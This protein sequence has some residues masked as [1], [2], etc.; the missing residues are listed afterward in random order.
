V[1]V[2]DHRQASPLRPLPPAFADSVASLHRVAESIVAPARKPDNEIA[3]T[4]TPGGFGTPEFEFAGALRQVRVEGAELVHRVGAD[5]RRAPLTTLAEAA[6]AVA[7]LLPPDTDL[8][9][10]AL[11]IDAA[12]VKAL[13]DCYA[14]GA[15]VLSELGA[16]TSPEDEATPPRLWPEHFD[17]AVELGDEAGGRRANYGL[18]PGDEDHAE[19][20]LYVGPWSAEVSG[21]L[22]QASGFKGAELTYSGLLAA[23]DQRAAALDFFVT[24]RD[25]LGNYKEAK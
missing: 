7:D 21:D 24:R 11:D 14:L 23:A 8:D 13:A 15:E 20:Y 9:D 19:P 5:Q 1:P 3:L 4:A 6:A 17:I 22:W 16:K 10:A 18:S 25:A 2:T 12:A